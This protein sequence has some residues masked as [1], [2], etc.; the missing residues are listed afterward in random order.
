MKWMLLVAMTAAVI[1]LAEP[2][3]LGCSISLAS[4]TTRQPKTPRR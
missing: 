3:N 1:Q 2:G 4:H